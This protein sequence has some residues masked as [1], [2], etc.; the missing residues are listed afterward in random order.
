MSPAASHR[1]GTAGGCRS[2]STPRQWVSRWS[3]AALAGAGWKSSWHRPTWCAPRTRWSPG[4]PPRRAVDS[5]DRAARFRGGPAGVGADHQAGLV[6]RLEGAG[7]DLLEQRDQAIRPLRVGAALEEPVAPVVGQDEPVVLHLDQDGL[8]VRAV[9]RGTGAEPGDAEA[10]L[11]P[12]PGTHRRQRR[13]RAR[14]RLVPG[15]PQVGRPRG[16][17]GEPDRV[18]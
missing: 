13:V 9:P 2:W 10:R 5:A 8:G 6:D 15:R 18:V 7:G 12:E 4:S 1:W 16:L 17:P 11:E 3:T 14:A